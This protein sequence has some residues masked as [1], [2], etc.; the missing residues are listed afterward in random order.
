[1]HRYTHI[2]RAMLWMAALFAIWALFWGRSYRLGE[3]HLSEAEVVA[4]SE[5]DARLF[6]RSFSTHLGLLSEIETA[7][8]KYD[9]QLLSTYSM[10]LEAQK[11]DLFGT[12]L[13]KIMHRYTH[14]FANILS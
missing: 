10:S 1:M 8:G 11:R 14:I 4:L 2:G 5:V 13:A 6:N 12:Y 9:T 7:F 3:E